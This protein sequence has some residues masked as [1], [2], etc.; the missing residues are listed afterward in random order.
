LSGGNS[1][2]FAR[3]FEELADIGYSEV[4][5]AGYTQ[6]G[7]GDITPEEIRQLLD[8]NGLRAVGSHRTLRPDNIDAELD[9]AEIL[10]TPF[11]GQGGAVT[12]NNTVAG[13]GQAADNWNL[14]GEKARARGIKL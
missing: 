9:I 5:F 11:L 12:N 6:G 14:M 10:G 2:G 13:W 7:A 8:D 3:L 1:I 4:E